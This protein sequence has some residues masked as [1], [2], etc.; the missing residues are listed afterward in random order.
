M[1]DV[2]TR[3][4]PAC[5]KRIT[6]TRAD[7]LRV[8]GRPNRRCPGSGSSGGTRSEETTAHD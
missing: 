7:V 8:H 1:P 2:R 5:R 6:V 3:V 4:C